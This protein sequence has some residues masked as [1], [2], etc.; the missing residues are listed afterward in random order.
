[1]AGDFSNGITAFKGLI[2]TINQVLGFNNHQ[3]ILM[4]RFSLDAIKNEAVLVLHIL[5][6][7]NHAKCSELRNF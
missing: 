5:T 2:W 4:P 3:I 7:K 6:K 1:M